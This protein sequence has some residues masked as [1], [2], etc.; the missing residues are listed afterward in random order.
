MDT[1]QTRIILHVPDN[2][3]SKFDFEHHQPHEQ[4]ELVLDVGTV[5][6][7]L[8]F[9]CICTL[10]N[11]PELFKIEMRY[12][13]LPQRQV[14]RLDLVGVVDLVDLVHDELVDG[15]VV[16]WVVVGRVL[17]FICVLRVVFLV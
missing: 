15:R 12:P 7:D 17:I 3:D 13:H 8:Q 14:Q 11:T 1:N 16:V 4:P 10:H 2:Q 5:E 6:L 9:V